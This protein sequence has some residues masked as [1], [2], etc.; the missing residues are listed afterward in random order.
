MAVA[1]L[2]GRLGGSQQL[3]IYVAVT[4]A[5]TLVIMV[6]TFA[7]EAHVVSRLKGQSSD[8]WVVALA[9][10]G[11]YAIALPVS[12]SGFIA[13]G[14]AVLLEA[15]HPATMVALLEVLIAPLLFTRV[16]LHA[17]GRQRPMAI[18]TVIGRSFWAVGASGTIVLLPHLALFGAIWF[19]F[20]GM[21][22]EAV[23]LAKIADCGIFR[24][25]VRYQ[26]NNGDEPGVWVTLKE[27]SPLGLS[28]AATALNQRLDALLLAALL[29]ASATGIYG[30]AV[31]LSEPFRMVGSALY[32]VIAPALVQAASAGN[33][34]VTR[35]AARDFALLLSAIT[36]LAAT[37]LA[38]LAPWVIPGLFGQEFTAAARLVPVLVLAE[39][40][41]LVGLIS[42][43]IA[44]ALDRRRSLAWSAG[45]AAGL[46]AVANLLLIPRLGVLGA[47]VASL[48]SYAIAGFSV[49]I[50]DGRVRAVGIGA[51][52]VSCAGIALTACTITLPWL[53]GWNPIFSP[54]LFAVV[55]PMLFPEALIRGLQMLSKV[56]ARAG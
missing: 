18:A 33:F 8:R 6:S 17:R 37:V 25:L 49:L 53:L 21:L 45:A 32:H 44:L 1:V 41:L 43:S 35:Q 10:R 27:A 50:L 42:T 51:L 3:G 30:A 28:G 4:A 47:A 22:I 40:G 2:L 26:P 5:S 20:C 54:L 36:G 48:G 24:N 19:R 52:R 23:L 39:V 16:Y 46:N 11:S 38:A 34:Q 9:M 7:L 12:V 29:G 55:W 31:K 14:I 15:L 56:M 13:V